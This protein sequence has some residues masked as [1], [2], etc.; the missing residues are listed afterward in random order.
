MGTFII[1]LLLMNLLIMKYLLLINVQNEH[2]ILELIPESLNPFII[3]LLT[4]TSINKLTSCTYD[5]IL[6]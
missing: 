5:L 2:L 6:L 3:Y 1:T 4:S